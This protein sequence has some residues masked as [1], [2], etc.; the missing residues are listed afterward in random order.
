MNYL[1]NN[2]FILFFFLSVLISDCDQQ[3]FKDINNNLSGKYLHLTFNNIFS[4]SID[5]ISGN[6]INVIINKDAKEF[7][8]DFNNSVLI[9]SNHK[10]MNYFKNTNQLYIDHMDS[11]LIKKIYNF[12]DFN[13]ADLLIIDNQYIYSNEDFDYTLLIDL[14]EGCNAIDLIK[15]SSKNFIFSSQEVHFKF[16]EN[17]K[18]MDYFKI[19]DLPSDYF[20]FDLR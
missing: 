1:I 17:Y 10:S 16:E 20:E 15:F 13:F 11:L 4:E 14:N 9:L 2:F 7:V 5:S 8:V 3:F 18:N 12:I 19:L 6:S